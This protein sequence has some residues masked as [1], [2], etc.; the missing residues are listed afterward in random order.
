MPQT[1]PAA[2]VDSTVKAEKPVKKHAKKKAHK[3]SAKKHKA[4]KHKKKAAM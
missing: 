2:A 3:V 4:A 1:A